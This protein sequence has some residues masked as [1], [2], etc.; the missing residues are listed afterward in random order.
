MLDNAVDPDVR[1][2]TFYIDLQEKPFNHFTFTDNGQGMVPDKLHKML[3]F[4]YCEK[5]Q[6]FQLS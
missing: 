2:K 4:G 5:V 1:A 6:T 3:S